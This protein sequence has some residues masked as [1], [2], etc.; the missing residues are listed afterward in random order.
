MQELSNRLK[1]T[2]KLFTASGKTS[3]AILWVLYSAM[4]AQSLA[5]HLLAGNLAKTRLS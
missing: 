2:K 4:E 5:M 3:R 1:T